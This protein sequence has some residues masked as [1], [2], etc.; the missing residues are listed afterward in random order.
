VEPD[1]ITYILYFSGT[2]ERLLHEMAAKVRYLLRH[3][4]DPLTANIGMGVTVETV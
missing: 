2:W 4:K 1:E 3:N